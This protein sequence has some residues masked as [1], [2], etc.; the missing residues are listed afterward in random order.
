VKITG[1]DCGTTVYDYHNAISNP[2]LNGGCMTKKGTPYCGYDG[3]EE[4][5]ARCKVVE[6]DAAFLLLG[7]VA[8]VG[9]AVV[10][11]LAHKRGSTV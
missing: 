2:L 8:C 11:F 4:I 9:A 1:V 3:L 7:F 5:S 10:C 6:A